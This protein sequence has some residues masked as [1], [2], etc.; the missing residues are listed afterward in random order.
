MGGMNVEASIKLAQT[1]RL[2]VIVSGGFDGVRDIDRIAS[3]R[4]SNASIEGI[5]AGRSLYEKRFDV[6]EALALC[7]RLGQC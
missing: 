1:S 4:S 2:P 5:I 3:S 6:E 7:E